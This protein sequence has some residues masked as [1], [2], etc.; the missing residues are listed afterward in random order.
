MDCSLPDFFCPW[1]SPGK[2]TTVGCHA[3]LLGIFLT[4]GSSPGIKPMSSALA[5][6]FFT[7]W[8]AWKAQIDSSFGFWGA[9]RSLSKILNSALVARNQ[10]RWYVNRRTWLNANKTLFVDTKMWISSNCQV[11]QYCPCFNFETFFFFPFLGCS[12]TKNGTLAACNGIWVLTTGPP[13]N[14]LFVTF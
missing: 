12:P 13:E 11:S 8:A 3:F 10:P 6:R 7:I 1:D 4:Q 5:G 14:S 9:T 2:S